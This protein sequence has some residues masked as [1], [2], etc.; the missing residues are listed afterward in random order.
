MGS[1]CTA[2]AVSAKK[3]PARSACNTQACAPSA[4]D[5]LWNAR[6]VPNARAQLATDTMNVLFTLTLNV[7]LFIKKLS[8]LTELVVWI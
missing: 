5:P 6:L 7:H 2:A 4:P 8:S 3:K 1:I